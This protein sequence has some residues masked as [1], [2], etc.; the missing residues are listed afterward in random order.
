MQIIN[1]KLAATS[2]GVISA[3]LGPKQPAKAIKITL[4][5][6]VSG[7]QS[8]VMTITGINEVNQT[9]N[10]I[11]SGNNIVGTIDGGTF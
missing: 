3:V 10:T 9:L 6:S 1:V 4:T 11:V 8:N 7:I 5:Q 2:N